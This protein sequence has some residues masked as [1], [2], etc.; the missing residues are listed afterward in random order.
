VHQTVRW[1]SRAHANGRQRNLRVTRGPR[2]RSPSRIALSGVP[3]D[4]PVCQ[5]V[6]GCNGRLRQKRKEIAHYSLSGGAPK[7]PV[8]PRTEG[9]YCLLNG[10]PTAPS[11]LGAIK[12][13][14]RRMEQYTRHLLNIL[15]HLDSPSTH[16]ILCVWDLSTCLS[17]ELVALCCVLVSWLVCVSLLRL[18]LLRVF[19]FPP[20][21]L[22]FK[23]D[24]SCKGDRLQLVEIPH[25]G[26]TW[27]KEENCGTQ[28]W[29]LDHLRGIE[30]N[31]LPKEV[32]TTWSRHWPNHGI[33][34]RCLLCDF[35]L[36]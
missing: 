26:N 1:A 15:R 16:L 23:C 13:T 20:L 28:V 33:K 24:Q 22:W 34:S 35:L 18:Y 2:Q 36:W 5:G 10:A 25:K 9:N 6:R 11:F 30:C 32:T 17:C 19:L 7:C 4:C 27:E 31:P 12:G 14:P 8:R 3:P 29:S 21:L